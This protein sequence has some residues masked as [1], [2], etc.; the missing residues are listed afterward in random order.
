MIQM[1]VEGKRDFVIA[2]QQTLSPFGRVDYYVD[3]AGTYFKPWLEVG[4]YHSWKVA[5]WLSVVSRASVLYD[6]GVFGQ[7][8]G[9]VA[10]YKGGL[11]WTLGKFTIELPAFKYTHPFM[12]EEGNPFNRI[13]RFILGGGVQFNY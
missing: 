1:Y 8:A 3:T 7:E 6:T 12:N 9:F 13:D 4:T 11:N 2:P 5:K 10:K